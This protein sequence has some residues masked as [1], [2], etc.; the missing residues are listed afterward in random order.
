MNT[1]TSILHQPPLSIGNGIKEE[2]VVINND[3]F[4]SIFSYLLKEDRDKIAQPNL[5]IGEKGSG[6]TSLLK[7]MYFSIENSAGKAQRSP[8][9]S[10]VQHGYASQ[11]Q[12]QAQP[13]HHGEFLLEDQGHDQSYHYRIDKEYGGCDAGFHVVVA[14]EECQG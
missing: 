4:T 9:A 13:R 7:R 3:I 1:S 8:V 11:C 10:F 14:L 5:I 2:T 12:Q 6:K